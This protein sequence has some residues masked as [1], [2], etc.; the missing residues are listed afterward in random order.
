MKSYIQL[1]FLFI[2]TG[3]ALPAVAG[4]LGYEFISVEYRNF[5][6]S[7]DGFSEDFEGEDISLDISLAVRPHVAV[8]AGYSKAS[9]N[10]TSSGTMVDAD[11]TA[12]T[13]GILGHASMSDTTDFIL[14]ARFIN[15]E[16]DVD[17]AGTYSTSVDRDGAVAFIGIRTMALDRLELDVYIQ[18]MS[19]EDTTNMGI[20]FI[21]AYYINKSVSLSLGYTMDADNNIFAFGIT[22]YFY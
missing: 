22:K 18:K 16:A 17:V 3:L 8:I 19:I 14:G 15:G 21:A 11:I 4:A 2:F 6:S 12:S 1:I 9:A 20:N 13:F 5:S 10:Q 7:I